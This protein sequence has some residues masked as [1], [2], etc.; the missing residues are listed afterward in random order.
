MDQSFDE[1]NPI[2]SLDKL[3]TS[4]IDKLETKHPDFE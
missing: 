2:Q 3:I 1:T 4:M